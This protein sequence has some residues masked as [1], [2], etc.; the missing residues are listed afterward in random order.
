MGGVVPD[1]IF[2]LTSIRAS[3]NLEIGEFPI[4]VWVICLIDSAKASVPADLKAKDL[5]PVLRA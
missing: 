4:K 2:A 1:V 5:C 3:A